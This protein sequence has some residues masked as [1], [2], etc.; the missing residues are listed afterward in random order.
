MMCHG[1]G[2][3]PDSDH[4]RVST[5]GFSNFFE[6]SAASGSLDAGISHLATNTTRRHEI[7]TLI[8]FKITFRLCV[9]ANLMRGG[10]QTQLAHRKARGSMQK[11][12]ALGS[13]FAFVALLCLLPV[14]RVEAAETS[15]LGK[16][17]APISNVSLIQGFNNITHV[18]ALQV[19]DHRCIAPPDL[20]VCSSKCSCYQT[21]RVSEDKT[22]RSCFLPRY[23]GPT[24]TTATCT[25]MKVSS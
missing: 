5:D 4:V 24:V 14:F 12:A 21:N 11:K 19:S 10:N 23:A 9:A 17:T 1:H 18:V 20:L 22:R 7:N 3:G 16:L 15:S 25:W 2:H 6:I 13:S 8:I